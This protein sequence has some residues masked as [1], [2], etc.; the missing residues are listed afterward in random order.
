[1]TRQNLVVSLTSTVSAGKRGEVMCEGVGVEVTC[2][3]VGVEVTCEG[4][5]VR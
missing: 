5:G 1:M 2:E 4:V 3:G